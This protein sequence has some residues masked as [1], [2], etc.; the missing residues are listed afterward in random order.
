MTEGLP[1]QEENKDEPKT[2][3]KNGAE[4]IPTSSAENTKPEVS[5][6]FLA[7]KEKIQN[8]ID[9]IKKNLSIDNLEEGKATLLA[10]E[11]ERNNL[12]NSSEAEEIDKR[13]G[14]IERLQLV[15]YTEADGEELFAEGYNLNK[16]PKKVIE[17][18]GVEDFLGSCNTFSEKFSLE[19]LHSVAE[20]EPALLN[21]MKTYDD[22]PKA[23]LDALLSKLS[24]ESREIFTVRLAAKDDLAIVRAQLDSIKKAGSISG[25]ELSKL[26]V[27]YKKLSQ[28][29]GIQNGNKIDHTR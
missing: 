9:E 7:K 19:F 2:P 11:A 18:E 26:T 24:P 20:I 27:E 25:D 12:E 8:E 4:N 21:V 10:K 1:P 6:E 22:M 29:L 28:A 5:S 17:V 14:M 15:E 23:E 13:P 3:E 16:G